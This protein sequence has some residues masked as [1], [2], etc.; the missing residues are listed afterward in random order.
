MNNISPI[1]SNVLA[2]VN[3]ATVNTVSSLP[4]PAPS[5]I[6][7]PQPEFVLPHVTLN[8]LRES[9]FLLNSRPA[10]ELLWRQQISDLSSVVKFQQENNYDVTT[11]LALLRLVE[12]L[13]SE[14]DELCKAASRV[15]FEVLDAKE[16]EEMLRRKKLENTR[17]RAATRAAKRFL[18]EVAPPVPS[19]ASTKQEAMSLQD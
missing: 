18:D 8:E 11:T 15:L 16:H 1:L 5:W 12:H 4:F 6:Q 13:K 19:P 3:T 2:P 9:A 14:A 7:R 17:T 10:Y